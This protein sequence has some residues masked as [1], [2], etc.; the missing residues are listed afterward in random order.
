[1]SD[2]VY[3]V[4]DSEEEIYWVEDPHTIKASFGSVTEV[5]E[6]QLVEPCD[7]TD[8]VNGNYLRD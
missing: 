6:F 8:E 5:T 4:V 1:M 2:Y 3:R 7:I